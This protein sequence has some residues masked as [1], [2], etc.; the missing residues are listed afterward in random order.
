VIFGH[1][2]L[3]LRLQRM[4]QDHATIFRIAST[5]EEGAQL[6]YQ[7]NDAFQQIHVKDKGMIWNTDLLET[8]KLQN[9]LPNALQAIY[10]VRNRTESRGAHAR[11]AHIR[12]AHAREYF[13]LCDDKNWMKH[14]L[15]WVVPNTGAIRVKYR[16][17]VH[18]TLN[19][20]EIE[21]IPLLTR[22]Y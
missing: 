16:Q 1:F 12:G 15:T 4:M 14:A 21:S 18:K 8:L 7:V 20:K 2:I 10:A 9:L 3:R 19:A 6:M 22:V 17:A 5:L 13:K 11:G